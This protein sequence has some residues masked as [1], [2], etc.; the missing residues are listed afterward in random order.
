MYKMNLQLFGGGGSSSGL[1]GG[2]G[3][4]PF[5]GMKIQTNEEGRIPYSFIYRDR[6]GKPK[7]GTIPARNEGHV[8]EILKEKKVHY[9]EK[10]LMAKNFFDKAREI[11]R[12]SGQKIDWE[13]AKKAYKKAYKKYLG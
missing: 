9:S 1:G 6:D 4:G 3:G 13:A 7:A 12:E 10:S 8:E 11:A 5:D 2:G